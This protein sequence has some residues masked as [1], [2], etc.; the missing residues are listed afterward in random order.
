VVVCKLYGRGDRK[1]RPFQYNLRIY[2][3][4]K[5]ASDVMLDLGSLGMFFSY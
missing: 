1:S 3:G 2:K 4:L 5:E